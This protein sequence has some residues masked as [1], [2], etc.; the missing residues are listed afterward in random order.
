MRRLTWPIWLIALL[1]LASCGDDTASPGPDVEAVDAEPQTIE[2]GVLVLG[3]G[4][5]SALTDGDIAEVAEVLEARLGDLDVDG[6]S[7]GTTRES[8]YLRVTVPADAEDVVRDALARHR[9]EF[10][11][12]L[13]RRALAAEDEPDDGRS[14]DPTSPVDAVD[15]D[16]TA[17]FRLGPV[18]L[19]S[20]A[21]ESATAEPTQ[22][23]W[24]VTVVFRSGPDGIGAFNGVAAACYRGEPSC[25]AQDGAV[26]AIAIVDD[27]VVLSAPSIQ[28]P[29]FERDEIMISGLP[30][31]TAARALAA[32][33]NAPSPEADWQLLDGPRSDG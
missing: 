19:D 23:T 21:V 14:L 16:R 12:V 22:G 5:S 6:S 9:V 24:A 27:L 3:S 10:R 15:L 7:V 31:E 30:D 13:A 8:A 33:L 25:P 1:L 17:V 28:T 32:A 2:I 26:G 20:N 11:P 4:S 18:V 29:R